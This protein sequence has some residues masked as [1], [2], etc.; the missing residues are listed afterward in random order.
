MIRI[1]KYVLKSGFAGLSYLNTSTLGVTVRG[2]SLLP[3]LKF[4]FSSGAAQAIVPMLVIYVKELLVTDRA[5]PTSAIFAVR[6]FPRRMLGDLRSICTMSRECK[7][8][9]PRATSNAIL[10]P[11]QKWRYSAYYY[12]D[13]EDLPKKTVPLEWNNVQPG[14]DFLWHLQTGAKRTEALYLLSP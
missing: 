12:T 1:C 14:R 10:R 8:T 6:S 13:C 9:S 11:L 2:P 4:R 5:K 3:I 7:W